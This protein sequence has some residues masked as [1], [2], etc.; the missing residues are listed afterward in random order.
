MFTVF[1]MILKKNF[2]AYN[3]DILHLSKC[4][5]FFKR[6][7]TLTIPDTVKNHVTRMGQN[8]RSYVDFY[9]LKVISI[10]ILKENGVLNLE[11]SELLVIPKWISFGENFKSIS[12]KLFFKNATFYDI[13]VG[14]ILYYWQCIQC[15]GISEYIKSFIQIYYVINLQ[16][17]YWYYIYLNNLYLT[18]YFNFYLIRKIVKKNVHFIKKQVGTSLDNIHI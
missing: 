7:S 10:Y 13:K 15:F 6:K 14:I 12:N 11:P 18:K 2:I 8:K 9:F 17:N 1:S 4:F 5:P 3:I 16:L